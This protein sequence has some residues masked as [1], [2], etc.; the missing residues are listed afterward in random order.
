MEIVPE[1]ECDNGRAAQART[2]VKVLGLEEKDI[3]V[4]CLSIVFYIGNIAQRWATSQ[5][6]AFHPPKKIPHVN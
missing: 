4:L 5:R 3:L 2:N 6:L 1:V